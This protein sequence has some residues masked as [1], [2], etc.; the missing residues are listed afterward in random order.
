V[1]KHAYHPDR[2]DIIHINFSPA[3]GQEFALAHFGVVISTVRFSKATGLCIVLP[4]TTKYH[5]DKKLQD[6]NLMV[7]VP[8]LPGMA[9]Q[10]WVY[11]HQ[12]K[13]IDYRERGATFKTKVGDDNLDFLIDIMERARAFIDPDSAT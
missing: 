10:G 11:T 8:K 12:I 6:T 3:A 7:Q 4:M 1:S 9:E 5:H 2:G 13:T